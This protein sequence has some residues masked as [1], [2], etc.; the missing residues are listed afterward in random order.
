MSNTTPK[1][2]RGP[3]ISQHQPTAKNPLGA[4]RPSKNTPENK[5]KI[6]DSITI[7]CTHKLACQMIGISESTLADWR[8][9]DPDFHDAITQAAGACERS[10]VAIVMSAGRGQQA[11]P[12]RG[13]TPAI[14]AVQGDWKAA[15]F[16]LERKWPEAWGRRFNLEHSG[17][18]GAPIQHQHEH[19][20]V[21]D[22]SHLTSDQQIQLYD[23]LTMAENGAVGGAKDGA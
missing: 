11:R 10:L 18:G 5:Q 15:A 7:G 3:R 8:R 13:T 16:M 6:V 2:K 23:L 20:N 21:Q 4:G 19:V 1:P 9:N 14:A 22:F 12:A 17:K